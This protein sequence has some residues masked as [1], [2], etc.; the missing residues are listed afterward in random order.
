MKAK[1]ANGDDAVRTRA[2]ARAIARAEFGRFYISERDVPELRQAA[3]KKP[4][5]KSKD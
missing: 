2:F 5:K 3:R 1:S 4:T